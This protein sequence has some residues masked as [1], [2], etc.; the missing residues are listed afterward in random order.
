MLSSLV[1]DVAGLCLLLFAENAQNSDLRIYIL[2]VKLS[3]FRSRTFL[4]VAHF[5]CTFVPS[6]MWRIQFIIHH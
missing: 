4:L 6:L 1:I 5:H 3:S 2:G